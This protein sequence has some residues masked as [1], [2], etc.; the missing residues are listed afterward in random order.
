MPILWSLKSLNLGWRIKKILFCGD[1]CT[2]ITT[3]PTCPS[4]QLV[5]RFF[6]RDFAFERKF[7]LPSL[8]KKK[9]MSL[10]RKEFLG[11][12]GLLLLLCIFLAR[13]RWRWWWWR[14]WVLWTSSHRLSANWVVHQG[15]HL[16]ELGSESGYACLSSS[17]PS[18]LW[19]SS[20]PEGVFGCKM[21]RRAWE[22]IPLFKVC[23]S[24][25]L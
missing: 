24:W 16:P 12:A 7:E 22:E 6:S 23:T 5:Y 11:E 17:L 8:T 2:H 15:F 25:Y 18:D 4:L 14:K 10:W 20:F 9:T 19:Y 21:W 3:Y 13:R 1:F